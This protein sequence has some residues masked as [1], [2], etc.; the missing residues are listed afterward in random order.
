MPASADMQIELIGCTSAGKSTLAAC[1]VASCRV[2]GIEVVKSDDF[3]LE[4]VRLQWIR[5]RLARTVLMDVL[6]L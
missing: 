6:S 2:R 5:R 4:R 3:V 1:I